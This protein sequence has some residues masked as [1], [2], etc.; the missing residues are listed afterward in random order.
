MNAAFAYMLA[1][2]LESLEKTYHVEARIQVFINGNRD[3][4]RP[5]VTNNDPSCFVSGKR[6][7]GHTV[8]ISIRCHVDIHLLLLYDKD[9]RLGIEE[10]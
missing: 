6:K 9:I 4:R 10:V 1:E 8:K 3:E 7:S 2:S 5:L